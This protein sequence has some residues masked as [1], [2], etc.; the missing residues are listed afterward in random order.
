MYA[1][2]VLGLDETAGERDVKLAYAKR[3]KSTRPDDDPVAFQKLHETYTAALSFVRWRQEHPEVDNDEDDEV[4]VFEDSLSPQP[5]T[6][7]PPPQSPVR[8]KIS[9]ADVERVSDIDA[10]PFELDLDQFTAELFERAMAEDAA[11]FRDWLGGVSLAW[12][13]AAK[14]VIGRHVLHHMLGNDP[15]IETAQLDAIVATLGLDDVLTAYDPLGLEQF[16]QRVAARHDEGRSDSLTVAVKRKT[17][18]FWEWADE[19]HTANRNRRAV[20]AIFFIVFALHALQ[21]LQTPYAPR[22]QNPQ[23]EPQHANSQDEQEALRQWNTARQLRDGPD[24]LAAIAIYDRIAADYK[25]PQT[26]LIEQIVVVAAYSKGYAFSQMGKRDEARLAYEDLERKFASSDVPIVR[27]WVANGLVN[28]GKLNFE[29]GKRDDALAVY[30]RVI[31]A[32]ISIPSEDLG[33]QVVK[34]LLGK[35]EIFR[36]RG[37][38]ADAIETCKLMQTQIVRWVDTEKWQQ[39]EIK[40]LVIDASAFQKALE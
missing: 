15:D 36:D 2:E 9:I 17:L 7:G 28:L 4:E 14:P 21:T 39:L 5:A 30:N 37:Q 23:K 24:K 35:A 22:P 20:A 34:A 29:T 19:L 11:D 33:L 16:R 31:A 38:K 40:S 8:P 18:K 12:P 3:L 25:D 27:R 10:E 6:L 1:L 26:P 13:L 32:Y